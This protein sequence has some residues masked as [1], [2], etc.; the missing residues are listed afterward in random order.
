VFFQSKLD[1]RTAFAEAAGTAISNAMEVSMVK[2]IPSISN[3]AGTLG[4]DLDDAKILAAIQSLVTN[5][6]DVSD[7][8]D[9]CF[10]L[11]SSQ[12]AAV[13][14]LKNYASSF[15]IQAGNTDAEGAK[16]LQA[17]LD[18]IYGIPVYFRSDAEMTVSGGKLGGLFYRDSV[19]IAIQRMPALR[20]PLPVP[21]TL[22]LE[23]LTWALYGISL[24]KPEVS[25][26]ILTK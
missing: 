8:N 25:V 24:I 10:V 6:V 4:S 11:P 3:T 13:H 17:T 26:K 14:S 2:L 20:Q 5:H 23:M 21:G 18:T 19:G 12:F 7:P 16:D 15:R 22:N 1:V 9:M